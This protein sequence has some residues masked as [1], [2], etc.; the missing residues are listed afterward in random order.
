MEALA[1]ESDQQQPEITV[2]IDPETDSVFMVHPKFPDRRLV[3][4]PEGAE[5]A[6]LLLLRG[7][8]AVRVLTQLDSGSSLA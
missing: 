5:Q 8:T 7:A 4:T 1:S 3:F 6:G 2:D